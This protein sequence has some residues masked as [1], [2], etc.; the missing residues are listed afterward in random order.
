MWPTPRCG[1]K[2]HVSS[3]LPRVMPIRDAFARDLCAYSE[4]DIQ[5]AIS[6]YFGR[7]DVGQSMCDRVWCS[8]PHFSAS[9]L[10]R[11]SRSSAHESMQI[12][13]TDEEKTLVRWITDLSHTGFPTSPALAVAMAEAIRRGRFQLSRT[14]PSYPRPIGKSWLDRFRKRHPEIQGA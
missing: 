11:T 5:S 6:A 4:S 10:W 7:I 8:P 13:S 9:H 14:P 3:F 1:H 12:L 2:P